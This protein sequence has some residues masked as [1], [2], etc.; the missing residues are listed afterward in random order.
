MKAENDPILAAREILV[1]DDEPNI[2]ATIS[3][4]LRK[5]GAT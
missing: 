4:I 5:Y 3:D 2:R 1:A